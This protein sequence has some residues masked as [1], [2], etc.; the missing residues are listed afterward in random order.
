VAADNM[1]AVVIMAT[2]D[3]MAVAG[4]TIGGKGFFRSGLG[5]SSGLAVIASH[6]A[7]RD[8]GLR[9]NSESDAPILQEQRI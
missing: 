9:T 2:V 1:A 4:T 7:A 8:D 3:T 5:E 6:S